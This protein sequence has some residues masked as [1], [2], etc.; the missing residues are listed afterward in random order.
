M[1]KSSREYIQRHVDNAMGSCERIIYH[2]AEID[3]YYS[4]LRHKIETGQ[5]QEGDFIP[6]SETDPYRKQREFV[7]KMAEFATELQEAIETI[8]SF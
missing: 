2:L 8:K 5:A 4:G 1:P 3:A 7:F 6:I